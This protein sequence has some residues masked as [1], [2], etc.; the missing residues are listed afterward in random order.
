MALDAA[1]F[2]LYYANFVRLHNWID[3]ICTL[4]PFNH[5]YFTMF[6]L[7]IKCLFSCPLVYSVVLWKKIVDWVTLEHT[8]ENL[9]SQ[10]NS[11]R[12]AQRTITKTC[13][14]YVFKHNSF[15]GDIEMSKNMILVIVFSINKFNLFLK[16]LVY[17]PISCVS[18]TYTDVWWMMYE[19]LLLLYE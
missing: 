19:F 9:E 3:N 11:V 13:W 6:K 12:F 7:E 17:K 10:Q 18:Q 2:D 15:I 5:L 1:P 14:G 8:I 4:L 16:L